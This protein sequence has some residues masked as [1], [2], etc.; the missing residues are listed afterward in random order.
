MR[1]AV[2]ACSPLVVGTHNVP[3]RVFSVGRLQ[4]HVAGTGIVVPTSPRFNVHRAEFPLPQWVFDACLKA[5]RL[6]ILSHFQPEFDK[7]DSAIHY[8]LLSQRAKLEEA[9][10]LLLVAEAHDVFHPGAVVPTAVKDDD[11]PGSGKMRDIALHVQL[12]LLPVRRSRE[13][14]ESE[15][16]RAYPFRDG[17]DGSTLAGGIATL[18]D[19]DHAQAL[20]LH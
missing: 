12:G 14:D 10:V 5:S 2:K 9:L 16:A 19:D 13:C 1:N 11:L 7:L 4:H 20:R 15:D 6:L 3:G 17:L 8:E 18:E